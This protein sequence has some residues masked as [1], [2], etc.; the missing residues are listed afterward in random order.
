MIC[1]SLAQHLVKMFSRGDI[2]LPTGDTPETRPLEDPG[3]EN[4]GGE[5]SR[6]VWPMSTLRVSMPRSS[7]SAFLWGL[8]TP[9]IL[10]GS[11]PHE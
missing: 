1:V 3:R 11:A 7:G 2:F 4:L 10:I 9:F 8:E 5:I 6:M